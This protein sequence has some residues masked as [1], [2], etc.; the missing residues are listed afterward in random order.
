[1]KKAHFIMFLGISFL[2]SFF[3]GCDSAAGTGNA[4]DLAG[5]WSF[6]WTEGV[7]TP[8][9]SDFTA[10]LALDHI[11]PAA[12]KDP[13][14]YVFTASGISITVTLGGSGTFSITASQEYGAGTVNVTIS[15][16][17]SIMSFSNTLAGA[18][19][20]GSYSGGIGCFMGCSGTCTAT[21]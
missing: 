8:D 20:S 4:P 12:G 16:G 11:V 13:A 6:V 2:V 5:T 15:N 14:L 10:I 3:A 7:S 17:G 19:F 18:S 9:I 21:R 1:M